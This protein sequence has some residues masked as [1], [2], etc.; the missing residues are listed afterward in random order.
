MPCPYVLQFCIAIPLLQLFLVIERTQPIHIDGILKLPALLLSS[1]K[2]LKE[3]QIVN[4][5]AMEV[6]QAVSFHL[7]RITGSWSFSLQFG[8]HMYGYHTCIIE[9]IRMD[10]E[11]FSF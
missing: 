9:Y 6:F 3:K 10:L 11:T 4:T 5:L 1:L 7:N 2:Y 8:H